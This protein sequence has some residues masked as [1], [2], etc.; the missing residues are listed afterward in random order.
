M[1]WLEQKF[2][3][4][5]IISAYDMSKTNFSYKWEHKNEKLES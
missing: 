2:E 4:V 1:D 3:C 5:S